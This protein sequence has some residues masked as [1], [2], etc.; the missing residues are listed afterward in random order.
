[1]DELIEIEQ[2]VRPRLRSLRNTLGL[3]RAGCRS[4]ARL[5]LLALTPLVGRDQPPR[6]ETTVRGTVTPTGARGLTH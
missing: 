4:R 2:V 6:R 5:S 1:M 3:S